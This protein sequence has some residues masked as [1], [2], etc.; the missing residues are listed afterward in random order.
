MNI[1]PVIFTIHIGKITLDLRWYGVFIVGSVM[2][3]AWVA[4]REMRRRGENSDYL[5]DGLVWALIA[6][7]IGARLWYVAND[8]LGGRT[9]YLENPISMLNITEGGLHFYGAVLIGGLAAYLYARHHKLDIWLI[10]DSV[11]PSLLISQALAR[12]ANFINQEL[13]GPPTDLP[14][15]IRISAEHRMPPWNQ[16]NLFPEET[17]RFHPTFAY[18]MIWNFLAAGLLLWISRRFPQKMKPG[19]VFAGWLVLAGLGRFIIE[20]FRPD[21]PRLPGTDVSYSRIVAGLMAIG[22]VI[23]LLVKYEVL[24]LPFLPSGPTSYAIAPSGSSPSVSQKP[25]KTN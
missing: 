22:G 20:W 1:D 5:W 6:G 16:L 3:G 19:A 9:R 4:A 7:M 10:L 2:V 15:G 12:P 14:W 17:T 8:I 11:A 23:L 18:E 13:Y 24:R 25:G 21:Q